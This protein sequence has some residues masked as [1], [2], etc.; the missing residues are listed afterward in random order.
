M[1]DTMKRCANCG[2][3]LQFLKRENIQLGKTGLLLG[4]WPNL[5]AGAQDLEFWVCPNCR[6]LDFYVPETQAMPGEEGT[7]AQT[8][9]PV[10]GTRHDL[11]DP[12]CPRCGAQNPKW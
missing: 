1:S 7:M 6:K 3:E 12:K 5:L 4:D 11:D 9:C 8:A 2:V 10:C